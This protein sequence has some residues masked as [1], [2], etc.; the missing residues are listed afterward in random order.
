MDNPD[1]IHIFTSSKAGVGDACRVPP[2]SSPSFMIFETVWFAREPGAPPD[3][4][5]EVEAGNVSCYASALVTD[6]TAPC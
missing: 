4:E 1:D 3:H 2:K 6:P 5:G